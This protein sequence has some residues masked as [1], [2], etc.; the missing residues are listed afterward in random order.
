M[1]LLNIVITEFKTAKHKPAARIIKQ[2]PI[3]CN[4]N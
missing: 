2:P 1:F 4:V 3:F